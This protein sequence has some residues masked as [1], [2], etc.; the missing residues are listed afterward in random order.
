MN[1]SINFDLNLYIILQAMYF[2]LPAYIANM[3]PPIAGWLKVAEF[4][5]KPIDGN[6]VYSDKKALFGSHKTWRGLIFGTFVGALT[7]ALQL[8][9][10]KFDFFR[11]LSLFDYM[12]IKY[13]LF[14]LVLPLGALLGDIAFSF[15]KRRLKIKPG[16]SWVF[17]D[18][19]DYVFGVFFIMLFYKELFVVIG[20]EIWL[21]LFITT[22]F[23]HI[24]ANFIGYK[25]K[26][27]KNWC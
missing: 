23:L 11:D 12:N 10:Y 18:Q 8:N 19:A 27:N 16:E 21:V 1:I 13:A 14:A 2:F 9:L 15:F 7:Y 22:F 6:K 17:F 20:Q 25:L 4:L 5:N 26:I 3:V 24:G